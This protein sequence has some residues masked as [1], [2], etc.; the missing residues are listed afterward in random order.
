MRKMTEIEERQ[1]RAMRFLA[2]ANPKK[3]T[4]SASYRGIN[5]DVGTAVRFYLLEEMHWWGTLSE[6]I[7]IWG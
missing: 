3:Y 2:K 4:L 1:Y 5:E 6:K 7:E